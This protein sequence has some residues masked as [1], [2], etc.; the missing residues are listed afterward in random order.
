MSVKLI[1]NAFNT[2]FKHYDFQVISKGIDF[3]QLPNYTIRITENGEDFEVEDTF[4][5][6]SAAKCMD[7]INFMDA[8]FQITCYLNNAT[9]LPLRDLTHN[10][11]RKWLKDNFEDITLIHRDFS[12]VPNPN[13]KELM[14]YKDTIEAASRTSYHK[15]QTV[16]D[17][18]MLE[19]DDLIN[20]GYVWTC[21]FMGLHALEKKEFRG[22][23]DNH[24][25]LYLYLLQKFHSLVLFLGRKTR[26]VLPDYQTFNICSNSTPFEEFDYINIVKEPEILQIPIAQR[27]EEAIKILDEKFNQMDHSKFVETLKNI[28]ID[29]VYCTDVKNAARTRLR[30]HKKTCK[31]CN[32]NEINV[33]QSI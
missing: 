22:K 21:C 10:C 31:I 7:Y 27:R 23:N 6:L 8:F 1:T 13:K 2:W 24:K 11:K 26:N 25:I 29:N 3:L 19:V 15:M 18:Y 16:F 5:I 12:R 33:D 4:A 14:Q 17:R 28:I 9:F 20:Y 32:S 30:Q